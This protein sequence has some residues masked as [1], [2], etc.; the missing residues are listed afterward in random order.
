METNVRASAL[1]I[2]GRSGVGKT[3]V[4][5]EVSAQLQRRE[6]AHCF[7]EGDFLD[8]AFPAPPGDPGRT[9]LTR[10][11]LRSLW[12]NYT[13]LGYRR[14]I[15]TNS[16]S[17][18]EID[19]IVDAMGG[20]VEVAAVLLTASESTARE[21][22]GER[23]IGSQLAAHLARSARLAEK[24]A[25]AAPPWVVRVPT[26]GRTVVRVAEDVLAATGW[27]P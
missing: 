21:R 20:A 7:I 16:Y 18:L 22:L 11:N 3:T 13:D 5:W 27:C 9:E 12:A 25:A 10:R 24:L 1:I 26:D 23:E 19:M 14:L 8:Q 6:V 17:V 4:A 15:Y 2:G